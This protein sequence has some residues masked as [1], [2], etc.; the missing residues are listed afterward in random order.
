M[1]SQVQSQREIEREGRVAKELSDLIVYFRCV[2]FDTLKHLVSGGVH[3][4]VSS[5]PENKIIQ[6]IQTNPKGVLLFN[7]AS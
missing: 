5:F 3:N 6:H 7:Q 2:N 4:E 1:N